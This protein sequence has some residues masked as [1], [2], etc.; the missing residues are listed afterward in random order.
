MSE[1]KILG[2]M[3]NTVDHTFESAN[4][5]YGVNGIAPTTPT[6][7][8]GVQPKVMEI[9]NIKEVPEVFKKFVYEIN[10]ERYLIRIRK[11]TPI[12]CWRLMGF[13]DIDYNKAQDVNS[14]TQLYKQAGN[15]IVKQ[16]LMNV[17]KKLYE[18]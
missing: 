15:S 13:S 2:C 3:G 7:A 8:G 6:C 17:F 16:V 10:G 14:K 18:E 9:Q 5:V 1:I 4:R 11:L 12:E